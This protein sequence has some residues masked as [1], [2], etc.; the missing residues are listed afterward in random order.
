MALALALC[1]LATA[2]AD[3]AVFGNI[4][5]QALSPTVLRVEPRGPQGFENRSTFMVTRGGRSSSAFVEKGLQLTAG[6]LPGEFVTSHYSVKFRSGVNA[7]VIQQGTCVA[8]QRGVRA[9]NAVHDYAHRDTDGILVANR[10]AC[11]AACDASVTCLAWQYSTTIIPPF[12]PGGT[13][14]VAMATD[15]GSL[16]RNSSGCLACMTSHAASLQGS[17]CTT[18]SVEA[19]CGGPSG[20][21]CWPMISFAET[22][23][24]EIF[25]LGFKNASRFTR[26]NFLVTSPTGKVL[27]DSELD[28]N[29][30]I[31]RLHWPPPLK[32]PSYAL[33]DRPRFHAPP[34]GATP[35]PATWDG[36]PVQVQ[37]KLI[38][39]SGYDFT[40]L[41][42]GDTYV[43]L[44]GDTLDQWQSSREDFIALTGPTPVLPDYAF[45]SW[46]TRWYHYTE[47]LAKAEIKRW[48]EDKLPLDVWALDLDWRNTSGDAE[49][50]YTHPNVSAFPG[51]PTPTALGPK[52]QPTEWFEYLRNE[53]LRTFLSDHPYPVA[54]R[55]STAGL[56][57]SKAEVNFR[58]AGLSAWMGKG[59]TFWWFDANWGHAIPPPMVNSSG[60]LEDWQG[61][62]NVAWGSSLYYQSAE[63]FNSE[64]RDP[65]GDTFYGGRSMMLGKFAVMDWRPG[66]D[67]HGSAE[68]PAH[69]RFPVWWTGDWV[70]LMGSVNTQV[71]GGIHGF[72][73]YVHSDCGGDHR[74]TG[75]DLIRWVAHCSFGSIM[76]LHGNDH[77]PWVYDDTIEADVRSY[78]NMRAKLA[79]SLIA[80]GHRATLTAFPPVARGDFYWPEHPE[81]AS[82]TQ[83]PFV[84]IFGLF[85]LD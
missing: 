84:L 31:N 21:N 32:G 30:A 53:S 69:H 65:A 58:W 20:S 27:Y 29:P 6:Q 72:K 82:N 34:W 44:L 57:T 61:L 55:D 70:D 63:R 62:T 46:F 23:P 22:S 52:Q 2:A 48:N 25:E 80:A 45:G 79:P 67:A 47:Q 19:F 5:I 8:P 75:G 54:R 64:V 49:Y 56:Q 71:D 36:K 33:V 26:P 37:P 41:V 85:I 13:C 38:E 74:Y 35:I 78:L 28:P 11:C 66:L 83:V 9:K 1:H 77:R 81:A 18:A 39:T 40:N 24:D 59:S 16:K 12:P 76:R 51:L 15:C 60:S 10:S 42:D 73:P 3:E 17:G 68:S 50:Y 7:S 14:A 4:R 43:F